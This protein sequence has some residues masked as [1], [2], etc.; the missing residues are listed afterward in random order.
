[1]SLFGCSTN[2]NFLWRFNEKG[3]PYHV[4]FSEENNKVIFIRVNEYVCHDLKTGKKVWSIKKILVYHTPTIFNNEL[5][6]KITENN[7]AR[8]NLNTGE[9]LQT[10]NIDASYV[11]LIQGELSNLM[12]FVSHK[13]SIGTL[14]VLDLSTGLIES[15]LEFKGSVG[16]PIIVGKDFLAIAIYIKFS[17]RK[18][19]F[20]NKKYIIQY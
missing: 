20:I 11:S 7:I 16:K 10:Y 8:F 6:G 12:Y 3:E 14:S 17:E 5:I 18:I 19:Y 4:F 9:C 1:M 2:R 13:D 15:L